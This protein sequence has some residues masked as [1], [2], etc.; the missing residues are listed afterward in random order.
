M[1]RVLISDSGPKTS[2][3]IYSFWRWENESD[4]TVDRVKEI[5]EYLLSLGINAFDISP[6]YG[7]GRLEALFGKA[8]QE[9]AVKR[10]EIVLFTKVT[11][12][13]VQEDGTFIFEALTEKSIQQQI[14]ASLIQLNT[15]Y[16]DVVLIEG[17]DPLMK[18]DAVASILTTLQLRGKVKHVGVS[19]FNVQQHKLIASR[20]SQ[21]V[22]TN[23][24]EL[25][26]LNTS[27]LE[28]GRIDFIKEQYSKPMAFAPLA[29]G[30]I[31]HG[32]DYQ[33]EIIRGVLN[34]LA[35]KYNSNIEQIAVAWIHKLGAL[36]IIGSLSKDRIRNAATASDIALTYQDWHAI[37]EIT[38]TL[39]A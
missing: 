2:D 21:E 12:K 14:E 34:D 3:S 18:V 1:K 11:N 13:H 23:H 15:D 24:F 20:L 7:K 25:N 38:K 16:L 33:A 32:H 27:A 28:D 39:N 9:L 17:F 26:L 22:V 6:L 8:L 36:P 37:Y 29:D 35:D 19:N 10:E 30:R 4:L 5:T 31:L